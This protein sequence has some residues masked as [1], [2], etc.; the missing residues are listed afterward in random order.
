MMPALALRYNS[1][2]AIH[3]SPNL[4]HYPHKKVLVVISFKYIYCS[5]WEKTLRTISISLSSFHFWAFCDWV[6]TSK[7]SKIT[8]LMEELDD[9]EENFSRK[10][11]YNTQIVGIQVNLIKISQL[12]TAHLKIPKDPLSLKRSLPHTIFFPS[13][14]VCCLILLEI[15]AQRT[16]T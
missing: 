16:A 4:Q 15:I 6:S 7:Y 13:K 12:I 11:I 3:F 10:R 1:T 5:F 2:P 8:I 14:A 9:V